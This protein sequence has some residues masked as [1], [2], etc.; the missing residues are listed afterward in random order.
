MR[1]FR[2]FCVFLFLGIS[3]GVLLF[4]LACCFRVFSGVFFAVVFAGFFACCFGVIICEL[5]G[6]FS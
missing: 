6:G 4:F 5:C 3:L 1:C 2:V